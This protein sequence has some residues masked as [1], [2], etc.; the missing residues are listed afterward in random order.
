MF[1]PSLLL[2]S[3]GKPV[4]KFA[5]EKQLAPLRRGPAGGRR[6]ADAREGDVVGLV[7]DAKA[8]TRLVSSLAPYTY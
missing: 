4:S 8:R 1:Q 7:T 6:D 5:L 3:S 2:L